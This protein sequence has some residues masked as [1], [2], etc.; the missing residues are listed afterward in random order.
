[1]KEP[2]PKKNTCYTHSHSLVEIDKK[3]KNIESKF[4]ESLFG[5]ERHMRSVHHFRWVIQTR[6]TDSWALHVTTVTGMDKTTH[7][8]PRWAW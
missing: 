2:L 3:R 1:M 8:F 4:N 5:E 7:E 6:T